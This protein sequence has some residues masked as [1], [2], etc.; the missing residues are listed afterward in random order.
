MAKGIVFFGSNG[1][2]KD[3]IYLA[4]EGLDYKNLNKYYLLSDVPVSN[5]LNL[6]HIGGF[7]Q[8]YNKTL[9][10]FSFVYQCGNVHNHTKRNIWY[11]EIKKN[12]LLPYTVI[13]SKAYVH[14]SA[15]IGKGCL[16]YPGVCIMGNVHIGENVILLPNTVISHDCNINDFTIINSNCVINGNVEIKKLCYLGAGTI[17][18]ENC[19]INKRIT[20]GMGSLL[21][22]N[23][24]D[25]GLYYGRPAKKKVF[26]N[27]V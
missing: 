26:N 16:I 23:L 18:K 5:K 22:S 21:T 10:G 17:V 25:E 1:G 9:S 12:G 19:K 11:S 15:I 20:I 14:S 4:Q 7:N 13:S 6:E 24:S 2:C 27:R 3:A 8:I